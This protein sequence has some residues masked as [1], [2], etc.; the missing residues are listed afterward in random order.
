MLLPVRFAEA[1]FKVESA[2]GDIFERGGEPL[3]QSQYIFLPVI[4]CQ[5][6]LKLI[7][8]SCTERQCSDLPDSLRCASR[9][10]RVSDALRH[11]PLLPDADRR[12]PRRP[13]AAVSSS[14]KD[15]LSGPEQLLVQ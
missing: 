10:E 5:A 15:A 8:D 6:N 11:L 12:A 13:A 9:C 4:Q 14:S 1:D 3:A 2:W 7:T